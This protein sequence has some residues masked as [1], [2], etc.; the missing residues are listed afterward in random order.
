MTQDF[1]NAIELHLKLLGIHAIS[2]RSRPKFKTF[3]GR[4]QVVAFVSFVQSKNK[5]PVVVHPY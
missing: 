1:L 4:F 3:F 5:Y 2:I